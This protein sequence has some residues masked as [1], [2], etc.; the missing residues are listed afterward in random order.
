MIAS[1]IIAAAE[2]VARRFQPR[3]LKMRGA[4]ASVYLVLLHD[5]RRGGRWGLYVGQT[6]RDP[7]ERFDQHKAGYKASS[8]V[9]HFGVQLLPGLVSHLNPMSGWEAI[10]VEAALA[11]ALRHAGIE[12]IEGGH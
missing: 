7:D 2:R 1:E 6:A 12:W 3:T 8:A 4:R 5:T 11:D 9:R 10:E